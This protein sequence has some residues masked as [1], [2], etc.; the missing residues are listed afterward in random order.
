MELNCGGEEELIPASSS[1]LI[2]LCI[3]QIVTDLSPDTAKMFS[4]HTEGRLM[5]SAAVLKYLE[6]I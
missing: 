6:L 2:G 5:L 1:V 4:S 3:D